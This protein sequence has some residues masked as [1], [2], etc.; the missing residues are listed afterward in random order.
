MEDVPVEFLLQ[1]I[2]GLCDL[3][4]FR[5]FSR[6][7]RGQFIKLLLAHRDCFFFLPQFADQPIH[8]RIR[9]FPGRSV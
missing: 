7:A 9:K 4:D 3:V 2:D 5:A 1:P 6:Q 8:F